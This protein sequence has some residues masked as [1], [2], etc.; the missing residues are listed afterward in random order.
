MAVRKLKQ[1]EAYDGSYA[2]LVLG[3]FNDLTLSEIERKLSWDEFCKKEV[4]RLDFKAKSLKSN[5]FYKPVDDD[6][7]ESNKRL[8]YRYLSTDEIE[9]WEVHKE[10][11]NE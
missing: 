4:M 5:T 6:W 10:K 2:G 1:A 8:L 9:Y 7:K 3:K 11:P